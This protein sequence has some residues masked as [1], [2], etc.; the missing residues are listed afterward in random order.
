MLKVLTLFAA[1]YAVWLTLSGYLDK[2]LLLSLGVVSALFALFL[3]FRMR[4]MDGEASPYMG[5]PRV[6][7]YW[8][9]LGGEIFKANILVAKSV[10]AADIKASPKFFKVPAKARSDMALTLYAN[11][12]TLTP[13]TVSVDFEGDELVVHALT[14]EL[15]EP[16]GFAE[17]NARA[18]KAC[19]LEAALERE[20][21]PLDLSEGDAS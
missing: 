7:P 16:S 8:A 19:I 12:I 20:F 6:L 10:L 4:I 11:A 1:L 18:R 3:T 15:A 5:W 13:G 14:E 21:G 9:W 17:M 2:T